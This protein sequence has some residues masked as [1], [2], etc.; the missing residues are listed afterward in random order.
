MT[1][2]QVPGYESLTTEQKAAFEVT[3]DRHMGAMGDKARE[4][5]GE[6]KEV[7]WDLE[8]ECLIVTFENDWFHYDWNHN[9]Y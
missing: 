4:A 2:N 1:L 9:W 6:V 3:L 8:E 5:L 7:S